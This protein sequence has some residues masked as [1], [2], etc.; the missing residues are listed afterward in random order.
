[1]DAEDIVKAAALLVSAKHTVHPSGGQ[2]VLEFSSS[3]AAQQ[4]YEAL[5]A[6]TIPPMKDGHVDTF[7]AYGNDNDNSLETRYARW[8]LE[9][10][11]L[12]AM[13]QTAFSPWMRQYE[14]YCTYEGKR[15]RV[16]GA[17]RLG[18]I[19]LN[20]NKNAVSGYDLRVN[21]EDCSN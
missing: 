6:A 11:R 5:K 9:Y 12:P 7:I 14:L 15:Y 18:D 16:T 10:F 1:M 17:S 3:E 2:L 21:C 13:L 4:M 19:W 8:V 20:T